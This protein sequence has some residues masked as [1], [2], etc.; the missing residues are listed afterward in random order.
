MAKE[1]SPEVPCPSREPF[2]SILPKPFKLRP[3]RD[4]VFYDSPT[5]KTLGTRV[6]LERSMMERIRKSHMLRIRYFIYLCKVGYLLETAAK[7]LDT[8]GKVDY[9]SLR[10]YLEIGPKQSKGTTIDD[11]YWEVGLQIQTALHVIRACL[12]SL[13]STSQMSGIADLTS[14]WKEVIPNQE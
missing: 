14:V 7:S 4:E 10:T 12:Q 13:V 6:E 11:R 8:T 9:T 3:I 1:N 2:Y 5:L